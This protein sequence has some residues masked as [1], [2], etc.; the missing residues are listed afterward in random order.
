MRNIYIDFDGVMINHLDKLVKLYNKD[1]EKDERFRQLKSSDIQTW[2]LDELELIN[3]TDRI[4]YFEDERFFNGLELREDFKEAIQKI[5]NSGIY[6][7]VIITMGSDR[8]IRLKTEF[9][10]KKMHNIGIEYSIICL[11][12]K[13]FEDKSHIDMSE[14]VFI[15]DSVRNIETS[16]AK[17]KILFG[18]KRGWNKSYRGVRLDNWGDIIEYLNID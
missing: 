10:D 3:Y 7:I 6:N 12:T 5:Q 2:N 8:N 9:I 15:D 17:T 14:A 11:N 13:E 1:F 16:N 4:K 18:D